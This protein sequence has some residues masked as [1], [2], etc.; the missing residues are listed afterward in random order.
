MTKHRGLFTTAL[1]FCSFVAAMAEKTAHK[2]YA[3]VIV[4]DA[5]TGQVLFD[6]NAD[7]QNPPASMANIAANNANRAGARCRNMVLPT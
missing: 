4:T 3:G 7:V 1:I 5:G 6:D 2:A